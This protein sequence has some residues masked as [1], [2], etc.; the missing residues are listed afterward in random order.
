MHLKISFGELLFHLRDKL[1]ILSIL[2]CWNERRVK[3]VYT[4]TNKF[5]SYT[6]CNTQMNVKY[7]AALDIQR[8]RD[9]NKSYDF[10]HKVSFDFQ[11]FEK[12]TQDINFKCF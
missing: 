7:F 2:H 6:S 9:I 4:A 12:Y 1:L 11:S 5:S 8:R 3:T 10:F